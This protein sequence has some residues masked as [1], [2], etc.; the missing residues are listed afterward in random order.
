MNDKIISD[1][2]KFYASS[3][4]FETL[5]KLLSEYKDLENSDINDSI[6]YSTV[7]TVKKEGK[8]VLIIGDI[9]EPFSLKGYLE[10]CKEQ[11]IKHECD[12]VVFIGDIIDNAFSSFHSTDPDGY[13]AGDELNRAIKK[14]AKWYKTFPKATVIIGNHDRMAYRKAFAGGIS[15]TWIK[16]YA[17]VLNT[18]NWEFVIDKEID[19]VLYIHGEAG[20]ARTKVKSEGRSVVS[21]HLHSQG[22]V[23][24]VNNNLFGMQVGTG[25]DQEA[26]AFAYGKAGKVAILSCGVVKNGKEG[27]LCKMV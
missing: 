13:G 9:H 12:T 6:N 26:Y 8:T 24:Y 23:E 15:K 27:I 10:F 20:T 22:Y 1:L 17:D 25:I 18:P 3:G 21:G 2:A 4:D 16:E 7:K 14:V 5:S 19:G 11:Y